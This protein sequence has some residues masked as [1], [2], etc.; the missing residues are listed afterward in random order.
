MTDF[1][2][3]NWRHLAV[4]GLILLAIALGVVIVIN[5]EPEVP[6]SGSEPA[7]AQPIADAAPLKS[8]STI[9]D[10][11]PARPQPEPEATI[12]NPPLPDNNP[13]PAG[14]DQLSDAEKIAA[15]PYGC[16]PDDQ[17]QIRMNLETGECQAAPDDSDDQ[18]A[19][20]QPP[21]TPNQV[22][23]ELNQ[24]FPVNAGG[25]ELEVVTTSF[26]CHQPGQRPGWGT[27]NASPTNSGDSDRQPTAVFQQ[28]LDGFKEC[29]A[30]FQATNV[31]S[32]WTFSD[33]CR[34]DDFDRFVKAKD[35][36]QNKTYRPFDWSGGLFC[37]QVQTPFPTGDSTET[38][39]FFSLPANVKID[40]LVVNN[41]QGGTVLVTGLDS[42]V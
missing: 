37:A 35:S 38:R 2:K 14:W 10:E 22:T 7:V 6:E 3:W 33:A 31:G 9:T 41:G 5:Q 17:G 32:D 42:S 25:L 39:V 30:K 4:G 28:E 36:R 21:A 18:A 40:A 8:P 11:T 13:L 34:L 24:K 20:P 1:K 27:G 29:L 16:R 26:A 23:V 15:N 12:D 19:E